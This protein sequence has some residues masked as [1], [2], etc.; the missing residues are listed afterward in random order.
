MDPV[1]VAQ[2]KTGRGAPPANPLALAAA[3]AAAHGLNDIYSAF[4]H[5]LLPRLM[6]KLGLNIALAAALTM[7]LSLAASLV[8]PIVG[9]L[10]DRIGRRWFVLL[11]PL[12]TAVFM[13]MI[14]LAPSFAVLLVFLALGGLGSAAFHPPGASL[15]AGNKDERMGARYSMFSFGGSLGY[16]LGPLIAVS[17]VARAGLESLWLAMLPMLV[18]IPILTFLIPADHHAHEA[19][20][21]RAARPPLWKLLRGPL[22]LVFGVSAAGALIQRVFLTLEPIL[23]SRAG[24]SETA[25]AL[26]LSVYL[27]AQA[28]GSVS[29]SFMS[30]RMDRRKLLMGLTFWSMPAHALAMSLPAGHA[31]SLIATA[32]AGFLNM[33]LLPPVV[34]MAQ[35]LVPGS[36]SLGAGIAMGL[37]WAT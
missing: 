2:A 31:A 6:Q 36:K 30:D 17:I 16:A 12:L 5:P 7:T 25:G 28:V 21:Q 4:L 35:E 10:A 22:G 14:G 11:G 34:L 8:Q 19:R 27:G 23:V 1:A 33:A 20:A 26:L 18:L 15:A 13:S 32:V 9:E 29:S 24:G 37:A 3:V